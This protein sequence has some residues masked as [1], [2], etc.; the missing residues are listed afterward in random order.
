MNHQGKLL[1]SRIA[2]GVVLTSFA[3]ICAAGEPCSPAPSNTDPPTM[4]PLKICALP[5]SLDSF[6]ACQAYASCCD[7]QSVSP[8][9][10]CSYARAGNVAECSCALSSGHEVR[11]DDSGG[12]V[13][14]HCG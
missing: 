2:A 1:F 11:C 8:P 5:A 13:T 7:A 4:A 9:T 12:T 3:W 14:C 10:T 6:A